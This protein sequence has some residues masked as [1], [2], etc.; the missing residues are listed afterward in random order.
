MGSCFAQAIGGR[1]RRFKFD[2]MIS[3]FGT[4]YNPLS[5]HKSLLYAIHQ[6]PPASHTYLSHAGNIHV[7]YDFH[8]SI[9]AGSQG[10]LVNRI[11]NLLGSAH[12]FLA[13]AS[14]ILITYGSAWVYAR[15][16]TGEIV[17]NCHKM[18]AQAFSK[19]LLTEA[20]ITSSFRQ[21]YDAAKQLNPSLRI[22]LTLSPVRHLRDTLELNSAGKAVIRAACH[23]LSQ[24]FQDVEYFPAYEVMID[25][26]RDYR[27]YRRDM[28]HPTEEAED[29]IWDKF[30]ERYFDA[31]TRS[32]IASWEGILAALRHKPFYAGSPGHQQFLRNTLS[33]IEALSPLLNVDEEIRLVRSQLI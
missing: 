15:S 13:R 16:E 28:L 7:N 14:N 20:E 30:A 6:E 5:I 23:Q 27:F 10:E 21:L 4:L 33:K 25:D 3:P 8:S 11:S 31:G 22:I 2:V 24:Q 32:V 29:Y 17:A 9:A 26:L 1:L 19:S 18:P 12:F